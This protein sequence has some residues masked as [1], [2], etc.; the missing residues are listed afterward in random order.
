[1]APALLRVQQGILNL[2]TSGGQIEP[3]LELI[4]QLQKELRVTTL[5]SE[6]TVKVD[7]LVKGV[8]FN[9]VDYSYPDTNNF[10]IQNLTLNFREN[11]ITALVGPSGSGKSTLV[12]LLLGVLSPERGSIL[13]F[14]QTPIDF[15]RSEPMSVSYVPQNTSLVEG[16]VRE[17][18]ALG[19][20]PSVFSDSEIWGSLK[21]AN[22][23]AYVR[24]LPDGLDTHI[25]IDGLSLSGG[26]QQ[27]LSLARAILTRPRLLVLDEATSNLDAETEDSISQAIH[28]LRGIT[29]VVMIAH[30][31]SSVRN[32]DEVLYLRD[33][34]LIASGDFESV[35]SQVP[36][37]NR[38]ANLMGF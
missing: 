8:H 12:D 21:F 36:D 18:V 14:G 22:L 25:G 10:R 6:S 26:Q 7:A 11:E 34:Y 16:T 5:D 13:L 28:N 37:F 31:L 27:R 38:Q 19:F 23:D 35:R 2:K 33:G 15:I 4:D 32:A 24:E 17:N 1:M 30:R 20:E 9:Q 3:T 29:T